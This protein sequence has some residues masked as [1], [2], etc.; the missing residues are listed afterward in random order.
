MGTD[1]ETVEAVKQ[2]VA[3]FEWLNDI[4]FLSKCTNPDV[5]KVILSKK[6]EPDFD[7]NE[8][9]IQLADVIWYQVSGNISEGKKEIARL[10]LDELA[11]TPWN[12]F[13]VWDTS[14]RRGFKFGLW[15]WNFY[16]GVFYLFKDKLLEV[17]Q[18]SLIRSRF[19]SISTLDVRFREHFLDCLFSSKE[20]TADNLKHYIQTG[21][22]V[23]F[24]FTVPPIPKNMLEATLFGSR[25]DL[26][27]F[28]F[29]QGLKI[30][31]HSF[32]IGANFVLSRQ[33]LIRKITLDRVAVK[34][35]FLSFMTLPTDLLRNSFLPFVYEL[36]FL[37]ASKDIWGDSTMNAPAVVLPLM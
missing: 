22:D 4:S 24:M 37:Q 29:S 17:V 1:G 25:I 28:L 35:L 15:S 33:L 30:P 8:R 20:F 19:D 5:A 36:E 11:I 23:N 21:L 12:L 14:L 2:V 10:C 9:A 31:S 7:A 18:L 26:A 32:L 27:H 13:Q 34:M 3:G 6:T 16:E